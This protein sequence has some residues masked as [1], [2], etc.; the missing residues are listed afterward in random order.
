MKKIKLLAIALVVSVAAFGQA[1]TWKADKVHSKLGFSITHLLV[2]DVEGSFKSVDITVTSSK[3]DFTDAVIELTAEA[4]SV[5]TDNDQRDEHLRGADFFDVEKF[6]TLTFKSKSLKKL[7]GKKYKLTGDLTLHG[8]TKPV[9]LD[10]VL[11]GTG[12][13]PMSKKTIAGFKVTGVIK[14]SDF[15]I[16]A[17]FPGAMLSDE[18]TLSAN[19]ELDKD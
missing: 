8:V 17:K 6:A 3:P 11:N 9:E 1:S 7:D 18:V 4:K 2:S 19:I 10:A 13:N 14:R 15:A 5:Y 16:G 12:V